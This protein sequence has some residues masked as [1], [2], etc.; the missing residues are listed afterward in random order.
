MGRPPTDRQIISYLYKN[1]EVLISNSSPM[2]ESI[3]PENPVV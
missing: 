3:E 1:Y 2:T